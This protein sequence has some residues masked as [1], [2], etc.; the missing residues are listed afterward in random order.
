MIRTSMSMTPG[1]P[2]RSNPILHSQLRGGLAGYYN[3]SDQYSKTVFPFS[4]ERE[5]IYMDINSPLDSEAYLGTLTH[6][7]QHAIHWTSDSSEETWVN[8]GLSEV[9]KGLVGY[10]MSFID[11]FTKLPTTSLTAWPLGNV[12]SREHYGA[13]SLFIEYLAQHLSLIHI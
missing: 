7:L 9:A 10:E 3:A 12:S 4:N 5:I 1:R 6:E 8:E 11:Y 13:A 2:F